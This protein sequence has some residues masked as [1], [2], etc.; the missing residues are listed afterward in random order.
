MYQPR[1]QKM[2]RARRETDM[3]I[4]ALAPGESCEEEGR[5]AS[6]VLVGEGVGFCEGG[7]LEG[8]ELD[9]DVGLVGDVEVGVVSDSC[10]SG[11]VD[12]DCKVVVTCVE[13]VVGTSSAVMTG[14]PVI[15][16]GP[17][18][19]GIPVFRS[20]SPYP[21]ALQPACTFIIASASSAFLHA[22]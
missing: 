6:G 3:A 19:M 17:A 2:E 1:M 9:D 14:D 20:T 15:E 7:R 22:F 21:A 4:A 10:C 13:V 12:G 8:E 18:G 11:R 16:D 5:R